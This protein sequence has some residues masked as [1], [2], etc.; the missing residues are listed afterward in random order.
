MTFSPLRDGLEFLK[1]YHDR[2]R[3]NLS[4]RLQELQI[5]LEKE[6]LVS[7]QQF[8]SKNMASPLSAFSW[9][10]VSTLDMSGYAFWVRKCE[11]FRAKKHCYSVGLQG[12]KVKFPQESHRGKIY[13]Y[14]VIKRDRERTNIRVRWQEP[15]ALLKWWNRLRIMG[16]TLVFSMRSSLLFSPHLHSTHHNLKVG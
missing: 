12:K 1:T 16:K 10:R 6:Y 2:V 4:E 14:L 3:L 8:V 13:M 15:K 11:G 9:L 7:E 5:F